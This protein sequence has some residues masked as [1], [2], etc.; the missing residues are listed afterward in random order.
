MELVNPFTIKLRKVLLSNWLYG[1]FLGLSLIVVFFSYVNTSVKVPIYHQEK[2]YQGTVLSKRKFDDSYLLTTQGKMN[3]QILVSSKIGQKIQVGNQVSFKGQAKR[4]EDTYY[5]FYQSSYSKKLAREGIYYRVTPTYFSILYQPSLR[6]R[7]KTFLYERLDSFQSKPKAYLKTFL[8]GDQSD[9]NSKIKSIYQTLGISHLFALSGMHISF[10]IG[11]I[12]C[13]LKKLKFNEKVCFFLSS[14]FLSGYFLIVSESPS[15]LRASLFFFLFKGN[16]VFDFHIEPYQLLLFIFSIFLLKDP[17]ILENVSFLY[18]FIISSSLIL[19]R[20]ALVSSK[21]WMTT[22]KVSLL[23]FI[24]SLPVTLYTQ[25]Q[26]NFLSILWNL[27]FVPLVSIFIFPLSFLVFFCPFLEP[28]FSLFLLIL[29][30]S[31]LFCHSISFLIFTYMKLP[32]LYYILL[33]VLFYVSFYKRKFFIFYFFLLFCHSFL[34]PSFKSDRLTMLDVGQGDAFLFES[35][36]KALLLDTGGKEG[37][38]VQDASFLAKELKARGI[39]SIQVLLSHGDLDH[40]GNLEDLLTK[41]KVSFIGLNLGEFSPCE[42]R[43][44]KLSAKKK[45]RIKQMQEQ[46]QISLGNF[47]FYQINREYQNENESSSVYFITN[48]KHALLFLAD[49]PVRVE[50]NLLKQ[51]DFQ[52]L[53]ILKVGHHGSKT[54]TGERL[55]QNQ[56][57]KIALISSGRNNFYHHPSLTVLE[58]LKKYQISVYN[59]QTVGSTQITFPNLKIKTVLV[60]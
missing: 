1:T 20:S 57:I 46:D 55:L 52:N 22:L 39:T 49:A 53:S 27:F 23:S 58:R 3:F 2:K 34:F 5:S 41:I 4:I 18:S 26:I 31:C 28:L 32:F 8:L 16:Q 13:L 38:N 19:L 60:S 35:K 43:I 37:V 21:K 54:S 30:K 29:E 11:G 24:V 50:E 42:K 6:F 45:I 10:L 51:Y 56:K 12:T 44:Q 40:A 36:G 25:Y 7:I 48:Q 59:T 9:L 14:L 15:I 47:T 33:F 17:F